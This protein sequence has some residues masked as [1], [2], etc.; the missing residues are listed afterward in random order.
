MVTHLPPVQVIGDE[1]SER[2]LVLIVTQD[3]S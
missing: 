2:K 1:A 3:V